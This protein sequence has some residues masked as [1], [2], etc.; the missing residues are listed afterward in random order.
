MPDNLEN[1][2]VLVLSAD[3]LKVSSAFRQRAV[4]RTPVNYVDFF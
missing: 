3:L 4:A 1:A 2:K